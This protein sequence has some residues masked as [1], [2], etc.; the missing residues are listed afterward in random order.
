LNVL[1]EGAVEGGGLQK[2]LFKL[3][4]GALIDWD[5]ILRDTNRF[6]DQL[7]AGFDK[8]TFAERQAAFNAMDEQFKQLRAEAQGENLIGRILGQGLGKT[9]TKMM[10]D[11]LMSLLMPAVTSVHVAETRSAAHHGLTLTALALASHHREHGEYPESLAALA[12]K[13]FKEV[14]KD[15]FVA[16]PL[17]YERTDKGYLLYSVGPNQKADGGLMETRL[18]MDDLSVQV[19]RPADAN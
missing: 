6:Y 2:T 10:G 15:P 4:T 14:P 11:V 1:A 17:R 5:D 7:A 18:G 8:P 13:Y 3:T 16:Q 12:P 19:P 9:A